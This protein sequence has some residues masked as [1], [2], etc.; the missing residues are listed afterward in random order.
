LIGI[1]GVMGNN[2]S[3]RTNEI[4]VRMALGAQRAEIM[5]M[6]LREGA[7]LGVAGLALGVGISLAVTRFIASSLF[8]VTP[9]DASTYVAVVV[10]MLAVGLFACYLPA[11]RASRVDPI[12]AIRT[13]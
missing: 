5:G 1:Y 10:L 3:Q 12:T 4:G 9:T 6:I 2:V 8:G 13:E 11:R 7:R